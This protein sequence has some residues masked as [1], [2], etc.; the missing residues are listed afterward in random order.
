MLNSCSENNDVSL[1]PVSITLNFSHAWGEDEVTSLD[2]NDIKFTNENGE[3]LSIEGLRYLISEITLTHVSGEVTT[4]NE[5]NLVNV[6]T[7]ENLSF[8]TSTS[9]LPGE[10]S[11][12]AFRFGF[13][14]ANNTSGIYTDLNTASFNVPG[15]LG[16]GYH[17]M[18]FDGKYIDNASAESSFNYH[19]IRAVDRTDP[20]NLIFQD[21]SFTTDLGAITVGGNTNVNIQ[22]DIAEW[23]K[24]P[25]TWD[26]NTLNVMLMGNFSA[27]EDM[28]ENG[29]TVFS[30]VDI[31]Q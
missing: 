12:I 23:F 27:Q 24:S 9:I 8:T 21:T 19:A 2:F 6:S 18:Q 1:D 11:N 16:G 22:M 13:S 31:T 5:Y 4:L 14:D 28:S 30:L 29:A 26:L 25:N 17:Y 3:L 15:M 20:N 10:Y 7:N